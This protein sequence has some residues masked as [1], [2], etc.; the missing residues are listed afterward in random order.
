MPRPIPEP[1]V[2]EPLLELIE[3]TRCYGSG[4]AQVTAL[5]S[6]SLK[7]MPG[8]FLSIMGPSGS[9]KSTML[10]LLG[11][12]DLPTSGTILVG[13]HEV[14][15]M[16]DDER[17]RVRGEQIGFVFQQFHLI[18]NLDARGN[19]ETAL[20]YRAGAGPGDRAEDPAR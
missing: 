16:A 5:D 19:V 1:P 20:L 4:E 11:C 13:G 10:G 12:L 7:I 2:D 18:P 14:S 9:G 6:V 15:A 3:V 8:D 17:S